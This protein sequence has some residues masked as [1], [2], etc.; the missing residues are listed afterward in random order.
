MQA[1]DLNWSKI[2]QAGKLQQSGEQWASK[3]TKQNKTKQNKKKI[4]ILGLEQTM[5]TIRTGTMLVN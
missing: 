1:I 5:I 3:R 2:E 4:N